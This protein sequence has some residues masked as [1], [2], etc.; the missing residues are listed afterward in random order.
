MHFHHVIVLGPEDE[1]SGEELA[2]S[3][4]IRLLFEEPVSDLEDWRR[5]KL[6]P[7]VF[8]LWG[9]QA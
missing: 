6:Y 3:K 7:S 4:R 8:W 5:D 1:P 9:K 2:I